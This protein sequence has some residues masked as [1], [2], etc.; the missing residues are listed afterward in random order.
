MNFVSLSSPEENRELPQSEPSGMEAQDCVI[1]VVDDDPAMRSLLHDVLCDRGCQVVE[2]ADAEEARVQIRYQHPQVVIADLN[3]PGGG[4]AFIRELRV[5]VPSCRIIL[6]TAFGTAQT[7]VQA[8]EHGVAAYLE[9]PVRMANL[10]AAVCQ[11]CPLNQ[12]L[13]CKQ[14][15]EHP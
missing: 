9:K 14:T 7:K 4:F 15:D 8:Q 6:I 3:M 12:L 13:L 11:A 2:A 10:K 1:L 5:L